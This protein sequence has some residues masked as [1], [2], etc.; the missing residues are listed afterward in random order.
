M[1]RAVVYAAITG[2][3]QLNTFGFTTDG[4]PANNYVIVNYGGEQRP[5]CLL[6]NGHP[7]FMVIRYGVQ[8][9]DPRLYRGP[10]HFSVWVH[11]IKEYSTD[12]DI[13]DS[14]NERLDDVLTSIVDTAGADGKT[15][16]TIELEGRS[17]D[18]FDESY[19]TVCMEN[20]YKMITHRTGSSLPA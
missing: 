2:D 13:I 16:C 4:T 19:S 20:S 14:V 7:M 5:P 10:R 9:I 8:D 1:S 3:T 15:V 17:R 12:Y 11:M 6:D 18:L